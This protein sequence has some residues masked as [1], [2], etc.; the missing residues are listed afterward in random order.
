MDIRQLANADLNLL[1]ALHVLLEENNVTRAA[2][3]LFITQPAM[4]KSLTRLREMF[5]DPLFTRHGH[6]M[7]PTPAAEALRQPILALIQQTQHIIT[8]QAFDPLT[9]EGELSIA[10]SEFIGL[11]I[12]PRLMHRLGTEAP[13]LR[14]KALSRVEHQLEQLALGQLDF[15]VHPQRTKYGADYDASLIGSIPPTLLAREGHPLADKAFDWNDLSRFPLVFLYMPDLDDLALM[16]SMTQLTDMN[17]ST[18][19]IET[20]H[21]LTALQ[22]LRSSDMVMPGPPL[23]VLGPRL[24]DGLVALPWPDELDLSID[25]LLVRHHRTK[26]SPLHNWFCALIWELVAEVRDEFELQPLDS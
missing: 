24:Q 6:G 22:V 7:L 11:L 23:L 4:S 15:A 8:P 1:V 5:D 12:I 17:R 21:L 3:R 9:Y 2:E 10:A 18:G 16:P 20:T 26:N 25:Y 13:G 19:G 14:I